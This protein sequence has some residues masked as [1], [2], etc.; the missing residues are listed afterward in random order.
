MRA[1]PLGPSLG[2]LRMNLRFEAFE[3]AGNEGIVMPVYG[4]VPRP[5]PRLST[6]G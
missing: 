2:E 3:A 5:R 4:T 6:A 1:G